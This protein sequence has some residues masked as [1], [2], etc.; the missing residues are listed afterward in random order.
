[1]PAFL[2]VMGPSQILKNALVGTGRRPLSYEPLWVRAQ[3]LNKNARH[4]LRGSHCLAYCATLLLGDQAWAHVAGSNQMLFLGGGGRG[5]GHCFGVIGSGEGPTR[6]QN[7]NLEACPSR[8]AVQPSPLLSPSNR[9]QT[10][11]CVALDSKA[12]MSGLPS[13]TK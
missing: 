10:C 12:N 11:V 2:R 8:A 13:K 1:M 5:G 3:A 7:H 4:K 9:R 6:Y